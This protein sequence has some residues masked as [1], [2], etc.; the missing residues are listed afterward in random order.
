LLVNIL[1]PLDRVVFSQYFG[2]FDQYE[3]LIVKENSSD[4]ER[5]DLVIV[6]ENV[7][8]PIQLKCR[9]GGLVFISGEPEEGVSYT[10]DFIRQ[11]D[12]VYSTHKVAKYA[13][14]QV[15][16]Q[17][18]N[19]WHFGLNYDDFSFNYSFNELLNLDAPNKTRDISVIC[20][21]L[22]QLPRHMQRVAFVKEI[23][24]HF[25]DRIDFFGRGFNFIPDKADA[26]LDYKFHICIE[27]T[28]N[29]DLWT[30]KLADPLLAYSIPIY[31]GCPNTN[32]YFPE[33]AYV[34]LDIDDIKGSIKMLDKLL[35]DIDAAY[36]ERFF[37]LT[38]ARQK[39]LNEYNMFAE[40]VKLVEQVD[41]SMNTFVSY[42]IKPNELTR[43]FRAKNL[44]LRLGRL[45]RR[46]VFKLWKLIS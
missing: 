29:K 38:K 11:F 42:R 17:C 41:P 34:K 32:N 4:D 22:E 33:L 40:I 46:N 13:K 15:P 18:F 12:I 21:S 6:F 16:K 26:L 7:R 19:D 8:T 20:S 9:A 5:W 3:G 30:E 1:H 28:V 25:R 35:N 27:N 14:C 24:K 10:N 36:Q 39:L 43:N 45:Y 44:N 37:A 31:S 23:K 2:F